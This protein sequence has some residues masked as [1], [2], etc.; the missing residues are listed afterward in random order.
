MGAYDYHRKRFRGYLSAN[1][2][3]HGYARFLHWGR[4]RYPSGGRIYLIQDNL[5]T[6]TVPET[7]AEVRR[8]RIAFVP[9]PSSPSHLNPFETQFRTI[10]RRAFT[11]TNNID[12]EEA[13]RALRHAIRRLNRFRCATNSLPAHR[14]WT[15]H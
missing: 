13:S 8:L 12:W 9:T 14:W 10:R 2:T 5:S 4:G 15:R 3:G 6:H 11:R 7:V 1:K